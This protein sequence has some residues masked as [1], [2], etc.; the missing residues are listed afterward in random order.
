M[1]EYKAW[2]EEEVEMEVKQTG[3]VIYDMIPVRG[4]N[5]GGT[6]FYELVAVDTTWNEVECPEF[7]EADERYVLYSGF[8]DSLR[9]SLG[10]AWYGNGSNKKYITV[11]RPYKCTVKRREVRFGEKFFEWLSQK[12]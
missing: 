9:S 6:L 10:D 1:R 4:E 5:T 7:K 8:S 12:L 2:C 3:Q 11:S